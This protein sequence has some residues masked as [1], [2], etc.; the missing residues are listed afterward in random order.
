MPTTT[1]ANCAQARRRIPVAATDPGVIPVRLIMTE[2]PADSASVP[3]P[4]RPAPLLL[5][6]D[7]I[8]RFLI[9]NASAL[10]S[11]DLERH[12]PVQA[13]EHELPPGEP[14]RRAPVGLHQELD[15]RLGP[16]QRVDLRPTSHHGA[17]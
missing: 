13:G 6:V 1:L 2:E 15:R 10:R 16:D 7:C 8:P 11:R 17:E 9:E 3:V 12:R 4:E 5:S 14:E